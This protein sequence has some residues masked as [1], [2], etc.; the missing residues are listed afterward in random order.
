MIK[1]GN[2]RFV[3]YTLFLAVFCFSAL[4]AQAQDKSKD[5][6]Q[7]REFCSENWSNGNR[8]SFQELRESTV[9]A[10]SLLTVD[11]QKNGGV[12]V[13]GSDRRDILVRACIQTWDTSE[14][15]AR[16][17]AKNVRI[18]TGS[19]IR[20]VGLEEESN[21]SVSYEIL[22]PRS[23]NL[24]L[25]TH[26]GGIGISGVDGSIDFTA[27]NGGIS[28]S[29]VSGDVRGRTTNGGV[30]VKLSGNSW[31]GRGLDIETTN[32]GVNLSMPE[33]YAAHLETRTVNGGFKSDF[34]LTVK[35]RDWNRGVNISTDLN[36]GGAPIRVVTTNGGVRIN[37]ANKSL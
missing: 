37:S 15:A 24:K 25:T 9:Q 19:T 23:M 33:N 20:A 16:N 31:K 4:A 22:V 1:S 21:M 30:N 8:R 14:E 27:M 17:R 28:L 7:N 10:G 26:N 6:W 11:G 18:E 2:N 3:F 35:M 34:D 32:G 13:K 12:R 29:E 36:G 5:N